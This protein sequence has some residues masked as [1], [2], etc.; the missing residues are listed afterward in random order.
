MTLNYRLFKQWNPEIYTCSLHW[1]LRIC[2]CYTS[3]NSGN[4]C[5]KGP[6]NW[7]EK[8]KTKNLRSLSVSL[9]LSSLPQKT[10]WQLQEPKG[11]RVFKKYIIC[12]K[13]HEWNKGNCVHS[14]WL[15][16]L[17]WVSHQ[18]VDRKKN[19]WHKLLEISAYSLPK[20]ALGRFRQ[21]LNS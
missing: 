3:T 6:N 19:N 15:T 17:P 5:E 21:H 12:L 11:R 20:E 13:S 4:Q 18:Y 8:K 1:G 10:K 9:S 7:R 16:W 14:T 2:L